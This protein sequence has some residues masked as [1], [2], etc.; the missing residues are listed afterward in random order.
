MSESLTVLL[1]TGSPWH[2]MSLVRGIPFSVVISLLRGLASFH[3]CGQLAFPILQIPSDFRRTKD[4]ALGHFFAVC[5]HFPEYSWQIKVHHKKPDG[6][7][8]KIRGG[9]IL[10]FGP[11]AYKYGRTFCAEGRSAVKPYFTRSPSKALF[12]RL[13]IS[14]T[15]CEYS[16]RNCLLCLPLTHN[17]SLDVFFFEQL[18]TN[19]C[20]VA[21]CCTLH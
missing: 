16:A 2:I 11:E 10:G 1:V 14:I 20:S 8:V 19:L 15:N 21:Q 18:Q 12:I 6:Q 4:R 9:L 5:R 13:R 17:L 7:G 3:R